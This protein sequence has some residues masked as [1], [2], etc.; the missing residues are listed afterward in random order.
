MAEKNGFIDMVDKWVLD[1]AFQQFVRWNLSGKGITLSIN[2]S[3]Y[4]LKKTIIAQYVLDL[5]KQYKIPTHQIE[6]ELTET[7][8]MENV[9]AGKALLEKLQKFKIVISVDDFGA[10]YSSLARLKTLPI[11]ILKIDKSFIQDID[12]D[13]NDSLIVK[14]II[15]LAKNL[16]LTTVAEGVERKK[17]QDILLEYGCDRI[18]GYYFSKPLDTEKMHEFLKKQG[19]IEE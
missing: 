9:E 14:S 6:L 12:V 8:I 1:Q 17:Q 2:L 18:Q 4:Q 10:G 5:T 3:A 11:N 19:F 7:A 16:K 15:T 13:L